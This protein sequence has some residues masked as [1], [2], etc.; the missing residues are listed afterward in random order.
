MYELLKIKSEDKVKHLIY[1][2]FSISGLPNVAEEGGKYTLDGGPSTRR[3]KD[4][5]SLTMSRLGS[6][7]LKD[8]FLSDFRTSVTVIKVNQNI[9]MIFNHTQLHTVN[10][11]IVL[12]P[13]PHRNI[14]VIEGCREQQ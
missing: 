8:L 2:L 6:Y 9:Y 14:E 13:P 5:V 12:L 11:Y 7:F 3:P 1:S 4:I 10:R